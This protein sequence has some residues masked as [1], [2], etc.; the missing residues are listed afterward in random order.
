MKKLFVALLCLTLMS[1]GCKNNKNVASAE[2]SVDS[3]V[4]NTGADI[5]ANSSEELMEMKSVVINKE[6]NL[7]VNDPFEILDAKISGETLSITVQY[8]GGC[9][10]H[11]FDLFGNGIYMKSLPPQTSVI[12]VHK[13]NN[14]KCRS[15]IEKVIE[16]DVSNLKYGK[17]GPVMINLQNYDKKIQYDY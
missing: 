15:L 12:L 4:E 8:S 17:S 9:E 16:F 14:D 6:L 5:Q 7:D 3:V 10:K 13:A 1:A 2:D 11:E